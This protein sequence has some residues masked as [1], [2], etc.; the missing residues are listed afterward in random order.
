MK[1][2]AEKIPDNRFLW[3]MRGLLN[4]GYMEDWR[5]N[6]IYSGV[7]QGGVVS[8][9]LSNLVLD[10]LDK[11]VEK[12]LIPDNTRGQ[13]RKM[14]PP[15]AAL[16]KAAAKA[17]KKGDLDTAWELTKQA[18]AMPSRV[19]NDE[20]FRRL[21]YVRY[22]DDFLLGFTG[23]KTEAL[24][25]KQRIAEFLRDEL[26]LQLSEEKT[27]ITHARDENAHFLGYEVHVLHADNQHDHRGRRCINGGIG[28]RVPGRVIEA[29]RAKFMRHGKPVHRPERLSD[30]AY[31]IVAQYQAE[32]SGLVQYYRLA[33]NLHMLGKLKRAAE[34]SLV[35]TL[36]NKLR[37]SCRKIYRRFRA[38]L[39]T[40]HGT[41]KVLMVKVERGPKKKPLVAHFGGLTL[42]RNKWAAIS[43][44]EPTA[45]SGRSEI[46]QRLLAQRCE[47][48]G[49]ENQVEVHHIRKLANLKGSSRGEKIMAGRHRKTLVVC[50]DCHQ[51]IHYGRYDGPALT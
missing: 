4:A 16:V 8:P 28:F 9:I 26:K 50:Q 18:Q 33:Y 25:I 34:V 2:L 1:I 48:C 51:R 13:R 47:L 21:W 41:F 20:N 15:Y 38:E 6:A 43:E 42:S 40:I 32:Y 49:S 35:K 17:R 3:L 22:A 45:W 14:S 27:L 5:F 37:C 46:Q 11:Y 10:K 7:P 30:S 44:R 31:S 23:P 12:Q 39:L 36:A 29:H 24:D 19:P